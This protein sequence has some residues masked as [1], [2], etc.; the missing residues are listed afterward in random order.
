MMTPYRFR[1]LAGKQRTAVKT[2]AKRAHRGQGGE[3]F[4]E[5]LHPPAFLINTDDGIRVLR[6][7]G[8]AEALELRRTAVIAA[9]RMTPA[10]NGRRSCAASCASSIVPSM[11]IMTALMQAPEKAQF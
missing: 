8:G 7:D 5:T 2:A 10:Q 3:A 6:A 1:Q 9:K 4:A 11:P